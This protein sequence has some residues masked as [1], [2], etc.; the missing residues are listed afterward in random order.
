MTKLLIV[1]DKVHIRMLLEQT[2]EDLLGDVELLVAKNGNEAL[3]LIKTQR[4]KL[5]ILDV[6]MPGMNGF[7]VCRIV[8][9][10]LL[11]DDIYII[12]LTA[13]S[14]EV[15]KEKGQE[16]GADC[17]IVKPFKPSEVLEKAKE[18]LGLS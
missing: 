6:M 9:K 7:E 10:E 11:L 5:V 1:D 8:K 14:Q 18:V 13:K 4:P 12:L 16:V 3:E 15:D 2:L 17:Y